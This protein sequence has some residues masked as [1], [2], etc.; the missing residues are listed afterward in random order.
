M[1]F[2]IANGA[3]DC[4]VRDAEFVGRSRKAE[5]SGGSLEARQ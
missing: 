1:I 5:V 3:A 2:E 4:A